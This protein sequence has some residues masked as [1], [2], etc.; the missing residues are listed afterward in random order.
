MREEV[1][2]LIA[3]RILK[4]KG[5]TNIKWLGKPYDIEAEKNDVKYAIEVKGSDISFTISWRQLRQMYLRYFHLKNHR[6]LL[7]FVTEEEWYC[8]FEMTDALLI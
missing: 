3:M 1:S 2:K 8:I 4:Q 7:M 5:F 6:I